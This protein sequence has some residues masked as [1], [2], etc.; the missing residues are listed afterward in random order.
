MLIDNGKVKDNHQEGIHR[1]LQKKGEKREGHHGC[2][3]MGEKGKHESEGFKV[4]D[5]AK[6]PRRA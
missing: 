4:P 1:K 5:N 3:G 6:T 2:M